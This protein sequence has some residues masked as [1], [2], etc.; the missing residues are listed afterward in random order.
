MLSSAP[1]E[2]LCQLT[3]TANRSCD[4]RAAPEVAKSFSI[5]EVKL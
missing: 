5:D 1:F 2:W 4:F 3:E